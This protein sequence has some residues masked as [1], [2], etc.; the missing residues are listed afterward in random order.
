MKASRSWT[1]NALSS[2][3]LI[4]AS[5]FGPAVR[6]R[7]SYSKSTSTCASSKASTKLPIVALSMFSSLGERKT[8]GTS[9]ASGESRTPPSTSGSEGEE[10]NGV[11]RGDG[12]L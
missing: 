7:P 6:V 9:D 1:A 11:S 2:T 5:I 10:V 4:L 8:E 12:P 3:S